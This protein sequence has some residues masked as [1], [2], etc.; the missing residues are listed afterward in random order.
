MVPADFPGPYPKV[1]LCELCFGLRGLC[2]KIGLRN[3]G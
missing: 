1:F 2:D 3:L